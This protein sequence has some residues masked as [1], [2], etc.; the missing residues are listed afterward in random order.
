MERD[1]A[2]GENGAESGGGA[3]GEGAASKPTKKRP[4]VTEPAPPPA[5]LSFYEVHLQH[6]AEAIE[7]AE[8]SEA[9]RLILRQPKSE[10][11]VNFPVRMD[12]GAWRQYTGYRVQHNNILGP[13]KGGM[14]FSP[15]VTQEEVKALAALMTYKCALLGVPF[16]GAKG[17]IRIKPWN[18]SRT[19]L[20]RVTRRFTHDLGNNIGP[21]YDIPAPDMGTNAQTMVW[22]MDT[23]MNG[24]SVNQKNAMRAV[25]TGKSVSA[26][27]SVGRDKATGQGVV[28]AIDEWAEERNFSLDGA[29]FTVQG[30]GN[31]GSH[32]ARIL[33]RAGAI[34][35]GVNDHTG[36][37][38]NASGIDPMALST[39]VAEHGGVS[40]YGRAEACTRDEFFGLAA[41]LFIPA[42]LEFQIGR[43]EAQLLQ[44][45][46][47]AEGANGPTTPEGEAVLTS[48]GIEIIPDILANAGGVVVSYFEWVQNRRSETWLLSEVDSRLKYMLGNAWQR[49][50]TFA[51]ERG[52]S[53]RT[54]SLAVAIRRLDEVY[55]ERGIF[56]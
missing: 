47:V 32:A 53:P 4:V 14:R 1:E 39:W 56:P 11:V 17:G 21:E 7:A 51:R 10:I 12:D 27:G 6:L 50:R 3:K 43:H 31:V 40:G 52:V 8:P 24:S 45:K 9:V 55:A 23:Y 20:E 37:I 5:D 25:V 44:V 35:V 49:M 48:K 34:L 16:G 29:T 46:C 28:Y 18:H 38:H 13:Y 42:A 19:E 15:H 22:M 33:S 36:S 41:D 54:A 26:G 30:F 2:A